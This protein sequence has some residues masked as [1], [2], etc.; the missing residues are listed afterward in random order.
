MTP[1]GSTPR[2]ASS[3]GTGPGRGGPAG[4]GPGRRGGRGTSPG[5]DVPPGALEGGEADGEAELAGP[6]RIESVSSR[7]FRLEMPRPWGTDVTSQHLIVTELHTSTGG[8]GTGFSWTVRAGGQAVRAMIDADCAPAVAGLPA[9]PESVWD[10]LHAFLRE[11]GGGVTT[12]AMAGIDI[13]LWDLRGRTAGLG[14]PDLIG[15][16]RDLVPA[17]ASGVNRHLSVAELS[18]RTSQQLAAGHTRFK[19]KV[20]LPDLDTDLERVAAVRAVIGPEALLMVDANQLWDLPAARRAARALEQFDIYWLEEPLP[21]EDYRGYADL[22]RSIAIPVAAGESLYTEAQFRELLLAGAIDF[23]QPNICRVGGITPFLRIARLAEQ[24]S[25]PVMPH[26]L[27]D[28]SGQLAMTLPLPPFVED[29]D[30]ASFAALGALAGPSGVDIAGGT[31]RAA[32]P[33]GHGFT[34]ATATMDE[35]T[36]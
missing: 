1:G 3:G 21:A 24:F 15:R 35:V 17:Y 31:L 12:L 36:G 28:F 4:T 19:M 7:L 16:Q 2:G 27:P 30:E 14:L 29:I 32:P 5:G 8:V 26:L 6:G 33:A 10:H 18:E 9:T 34:F 25:V 23:I 22:R 13:A 11:S 20:G